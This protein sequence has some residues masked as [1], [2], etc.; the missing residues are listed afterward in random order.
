[1]EFQLVQIWLLGKKDILTRGHMYVTTYY[2]ISFATRSQKRIQTVNY[3]LK[4]HSWTA[5]KVFPFF[6]RFF[7]VTEYFFTYKSAAHIL[8]IQFRIGILLPK[9][10][11]PTLTNFVLVNLF[12]QWKF[13]TI[14]GNRMLF[15]LVPGGFS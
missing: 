9:L 12:K 1:M 13:R 8:I 4:M 10:F 11:W 5:T 14:L 7:Y 6:E 3:W 15:K 2:I